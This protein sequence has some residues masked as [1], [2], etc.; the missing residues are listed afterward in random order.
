MDIRP[1]P[2]TE[3]CLYKGVPFS[4]D[5]K[6]I[7]LFEEKGTQTNYF[8]SLEKKEFF[9]SSYVRSSRGTI[10][11]KANKEE[12]LQYNYMSFTNEL[13][14]DKVFY[15]FITGVTYVNPNT[16][17]VS[18]M[19]DEW[20]TW[21]FDIT[22]RESFIERKHCK[23]WNSDGTPVI[24]T[25]PENLEIGRQYYVK[26]HQQYNNNL[27]WVCFVSSY[28]EYTYIEEDVP[29]PMA[30][31]FC[32]IYKTTDNVIANWNF[33]GTNMP[34][35][36]TL[37]NDAFPKDDLVNTLKSAIM[38]ENPPFEF[39]YRIDDNRIYITSDDLSLALR[40][41]IGNKGWNMLRYIG[42]FNGVP[43]RTTRNFTKYGNL[44]DKIRRSN[45]DKG[46]SKLLMYPY[47]FV[48]LL[49][50]Q[51]DVFDIELEYLADSQIRV[52]TYTS[53]G[54]SSK[55]AHI[56]EN[57]RHKPSDVNLGACRW[58]LSN[59][60]INGSPNQLTIVDEYSAAY[61]Q[62]NRNQIEQT[63]ANT[64]AQASLNIKL[65]ENTSKANI[66]AGLVS[67]AG[68]TLG[69]VANSLGNG[70]VVG[71]VTNAV[72]GFTSTA[73]QSLANEI[74][75]E[76]NI[77]NTALQG[78][79]TSEKAIASAIAKYNDAE[80][81]PPNVAL[82]GGDVFFTFQNQFAGYC[83]VYK[84]ISDEYIKII[85]DYFR[86]Y[87]YAYNQI[88]KPNLHTR[89]YWDYIRTIDCN[90]TGLLNENSL[91]RIK[92]IFNNG[93]TV[94]HTADIGNYSLDNNEI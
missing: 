6:N 42:G 88:E 37:I 81:V 33:N 48:Q 17:Y 4:I 7:L 52:T 93:V 56:V 29:N 72:G 36:S 2:N 24:N 65:A 44:V 12:L 28:V 68:E 91:E 69:R 41:A 21:C 35:A 9:N 89:Q 66:N 25:Q 62:G 5:Y 30:L 49:D 46:E 61:L 14:G 67:G 77:E 18:F 16:S 76:A 11:V 19:I 22:F 85:S 32:P 59:G 84:Q 74:I 79:L 94:W 45:N 39:S 51:G 92:E 87:G 54:N 20:Q 75:G 58:E 27:T 86:K 71:A 26:D 1:T 78:N 73:S 38:I 50:G 60:I 13:Y 70:N 31:Y 43:H 8:K 63:I 53:G 3:V 57:Y 64:Q 15:A 10:K 82:Q 23:R 83:L 40:E 47:S 80:N 55:Q 90:I 34:T